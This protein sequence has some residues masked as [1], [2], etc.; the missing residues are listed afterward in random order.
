MTHGK[1]GG[2]ASVSE[3]IHTW[4]GDCQFVFTPP[5]TIYGSTR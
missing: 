4:E 2:R 3:D 5:D 1:R